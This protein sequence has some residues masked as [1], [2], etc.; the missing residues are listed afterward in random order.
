MYLLEPGKLELGFGPKGVNTYYS[1]NSITMEEIKSVDKVITSK[2]IKLENTK[3]IRDDENH[4]YNV[5]LSS[6]QIDNE[7][8]LI[9]YIDVNCQDE[10]E[11][12]PVYLTK[13]RYSEIL[14]KVNHFLNLAKQYVS[15][16][17]EE[18]MLTYLMSS[19]ETGLY[20]DHVKYSELWVQNVDPTIESHQGF[21]EVYRDPDGTRAEYEGFVACADPKESRILHNLVNSSK[22]IFLL[23]PLLPEYQLKSFN[24]P[25]LNAI[26][27]LSLVASI[28]MAGMKLP[29]YPEVCQ[30]TGFKTFTVTNLIN[31]LEK[32]KEDFYF[33]DDR[34]AEIVA[35][36]F[37]RSHLISTSLHESYG[38]G[39]GAL[40]YKKDIT[41]GNKV[42]DLID[43]EKYVDTF[44][45]EGQD[46][47]QTFG[48][49]YQQIEECRAD[50]TA[51]YLS[52][53]DKILDIFEIDKNKK[54]RRYITMTV[55]LRK[56][57]NALEH[58]NRYSQETHQWKSAH[59]AGEFAILKA[60]LKWGNGCIDLV[61]QDQGFKL[62]ID[63]EKLDNIKEALEKLLIFLNY[64]KSTNKVKEGTEFF[65]D[66]TAMDEKFLKLQKNKPENKSTTYLFTGAIV[67][68]VDKEKEEYNLTAQVKG[69]KATILDSLFYSLKN[70]QTASQ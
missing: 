35:K 53:D 39:S 24:P 36:Y 14:K 70:I 37:N 3:I 17:K 7:G 15:N 33:F 27:I 47:Q 32:Q 56:I 25:S 40:I 50:T 57:H 58:L 9:G 4:R 48:E 64:Y 59:A 49:I 23:L 38:H 41:N 43:P 28:Y 46:A 30:K 19:Y 8:E 11:K 54:Y 65:N 52:F 61:E 18:R 51:I 62:I 29:N 13:G 6:I 69:E 42:R 2:N 63:E 16:E 12:W 45:E 21:I 22:D 68:I 26:N 55:F 5:L 34:I 20:T 10:S 67:E 1:P 66:L 31:A 60:S 44:Y